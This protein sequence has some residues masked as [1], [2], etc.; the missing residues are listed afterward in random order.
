M[1]ALSV[2]GLCPSCFDFKPVGG[3]DG[4][5]GG[6]DLALPANADLS[7]LPG[8]FSTVSADLATPLGGTGPGRWGS[9]PTGYCCAGD[10][11]CR[12][13]ACVTGAKGR[14][15]VDTCYSDEACV[16]RVK[17]FHCDMKT[18][19]CVPNDA[20]FA[21]VPAAEFPTGGK[22]LGTCCTATH[23]GNA[24]NECEGGHC[25]SFATDGNPYICVNA[26]TSDAQCP[27]AYLCTV[28]GDGYKICFP[29]GDPYTCAN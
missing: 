19:Q 11:D 7:G 21:C 17:P 13:R 25:S 9:L 5:G 26:C 2:L 18:N 27:G 3:S 20:N 1:C 22:K 12:D 28:T 6:N 24:G 23:D 14:F 10:A 4:G 8:D 29:D 15:C 16:G